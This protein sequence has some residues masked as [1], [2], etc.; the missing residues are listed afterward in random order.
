MHANQPS[1]LEPQKKLRVTAAVPGG[2]DLQIQ[3]NL[4]MI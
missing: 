2:L 3:S 1:W 4:N